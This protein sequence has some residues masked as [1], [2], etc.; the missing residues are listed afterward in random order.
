MKN[1][2]SKRNFYRLAILSLSLFALAAISSART[3]MATSVNIVNNS[4]KEIRSVYLSHVNVDDW[5]G[6]QLSSGAIIAPGQS[7]SLSNIAC[8]QQQVKV[9]GEDQDGC[10]VST[11]VNCGD[12]ATW[13]V[14]NAA[15]RDCG[16]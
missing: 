1:S 16:D 3:P 9:I 6:N 4:S 7:Y 5:S 11:I 10:F 8:D 12:N 14:T 13:T 2:R 15:A